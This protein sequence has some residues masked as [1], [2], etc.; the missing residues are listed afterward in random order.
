M[1]ELLKGFKKDKDECQVLNYDDLLKENE[2]LHKEVYNW[3]ETSGYMEYLYNESKEENELLKDENG[4]LNDMCF[5]LTQENSLSDN[6][7]K[8][9]ES[10]L[11]DYYKIKD[12]KLERLEDYFLYGT[13]NDYYKG[14]YMQDNSMLNVLDKITNERNTYKEVINIMCDKFNISHDSVL[15]IIDDMSR[16]KSVENER[17]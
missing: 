9:L 8:E 16:N 13:D 12:K 1:L 10:D 17:V 7:I 2:K 4:R 6:Y 11:D 15:D 14:K 5:N 3:M